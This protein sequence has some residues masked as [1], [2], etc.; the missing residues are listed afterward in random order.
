M[1]TFPPPPPPPTYTQKTRHSTDI[2]YDSD[3]KLEASVK[4]GC[5]VIIKDKTSRSA[6]IKL[7][8]ASIIALFFMIGEVIGESETVCVYFVMV[9]YG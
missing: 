2:D 7:V 3:S 9:P 4:C 6:N 8:I 5:H 1:C